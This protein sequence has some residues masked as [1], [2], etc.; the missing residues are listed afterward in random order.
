M[1]I[2]PS[3]YFIGIW[4]IPFLLSF[5][6]WSY[7]VS[8]IDESL[9]MYILLLFVVVMLSSY[10][11][12][13]IFP[14]KIHRPIKYKGFDN[15][16]TV[17]RKILFFTVLPISI[18]LI[19]ISHFESVP[20]LLYLGV[21]SVGY[22]EFTE[23]LGVLHH[24]LFKSS[25]LVL[26]LISFYLYSIRKNSK[27]LFLWILMFVIAF[28][29]VSRSLMIGMLIQATILTILNNK[30]N[31]K[32]FLKALLFIYLFSLLFG[33]IGM[34]RV[35]DSHGMEV[36][37][38]TES[39]PEMFPDG[40]LMLYVYLVSPLSNLSNNI[41]I[42]N[43]ISFN[44][45]DVFYNFI[46]SSFV[47]EVFTKSDLEFKLFVDTFNTETFLHDYLSAF[48]YLGLLPVIFLYFLVFN[49]VHFLSLRSIKWKLI[50]VVILYGISLTI[51]SNSLS[52]VQFAQALF[53]Y[54]IFTKTSIRKKHV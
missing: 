14:K 28:I 46:P 32:K 19:E 4:S 21:E 38:Q 44:P 15:Y 11:G 13:V 5:L 1:N 31:Y 35:G 34:V 42:Y 17:N 50:Y 8:A 43:A 25:F 6:G 12:T 22:N 7:G 10:M 18:L 51:F 9:L 37:R 26:S 40:L 33:Y 41:D 48:G 2:N 52:P 53:I 47:H 39:F 16:N 27:Y 45:I 29:L 36:Y 49:L 3:I 54:I 24:L 23:Y 30:F 20:G